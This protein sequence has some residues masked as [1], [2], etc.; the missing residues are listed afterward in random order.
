MQ[1]CSHVIAPLN[2]I[3]A[4][5]L[6]QRGRRVKELASRM[7]TMA[8]LCNMDAQQASA[9]VGSFMCS[10]SIQAV[11]LLCDVS[12]ALGKFHI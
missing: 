5:N 12:G 4:E 8:G 10:Q 11:R 6:G 7:Y 1:T 2:D 3:I 9:L